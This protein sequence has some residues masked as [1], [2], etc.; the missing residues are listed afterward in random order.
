MQCERCGTDELDCQCVR[1]MTTAEHREFHGV[2]LE[3][4]GDERSERQDD[5]NWRQQSPFGTAQIVW[6]PS[7][8]IGLLAIGAILLALLFIALPLALLFG[9]LAL[10]WQWRR[11]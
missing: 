2:T 5:A 1:T 3:D 4:G 7:G 11:K 10:F 6:R 8:W 9:V